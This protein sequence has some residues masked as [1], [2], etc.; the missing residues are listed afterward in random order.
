MP[1]L[2]NTHM[3]RNTINRHFSLL[4]A[5]AVAESFTVNDCV[6]PSL[7]SHMIKEKVGHD[8]FISMLT[9]VSRGWSN[10]KQMIPYVMN[11]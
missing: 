8:L 10:V 5:S 9:F 6:S 1:L 11:S 4:V 2:F 3:I 7:P